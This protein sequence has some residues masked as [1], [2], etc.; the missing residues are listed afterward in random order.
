MKK[1]L[2]ILV[3]CYASLLAAQ[4]EAIPDSIRQNMYK[5]AGI[6]QGMAYNKAG[7]WCMLIHPDSSVLFSR[8]ALAIGL[9]YGNIEVQG[10]ALGIMAESYFYQS[11]FDSSVTCYWKA[12]TICEKT[13]NRKKLANYLNGVGTVFY[14]MG[15]FN[16]AAFYM[17]KAAKIKLEDG[18]MVAYGIILTNLAAVFQ[19]WEKYE[20]SIR[21][22][23]TA[24]KILTGTPYTGILAN[25]YNSMGSAFQLG[26]NNL[27]SAEFYYLKNVEMI[28]QPELET[29]RL[30]A[31]A[32]LGELYLQKN[33]LDQAEFYLQKAL[34]LSFTFQ[35]RAERASIYQRLG[36]LYEKKGVFEKA[37]AFQKKE[38]LLKDSIFTEDNQVVVQQLETQY[39][40][41]KKDAQIK[42]QQLAIQKRKNRENTLVFISILIVLLLATV[43]L[44]FILRTRAKTELEKTKSRIF[45]NIVH[46]IRTPLTLIHGPLQLLKK[47]YED[48][49]SKE[50]FRLIERN[51][52]RLM[53]LVDELLVAAKLEK[54][55]Y[56][57]HYQVGD[58][59]LFTR[60]LVHSFATQAEEKNIQLSFKANKEEALINFA[61][62]AFE[63]ILVNLVS[64]AIKYNPQGGR[65]EVEL[66][67]SGKNIQIRVS[68]TGIGMSRKDRERIFER[69]Y[70]V[71]HAM[72]QA[73]FGIGLS[74]VK[75]LVDLCKGHIA[76]ESSEGVGTTITVNVPYHPVAAELGPEHSA[77]TGRL[78]LL[79]EDDE[80]I[81]R[82]IKDILLKQA[83]HI[84]QAHDG[85]EG[86]RLALD[87]VP[88]MII[89]DIM[90]PVEDG[91]SM[92]GRLK[93]HE[94]TRQIPI[95]M[96]SSRQSIGSRLEGMGVGADAYLAKPFNPDE[97]VLQVKNILQT[98]QHNR[99]LYT[100]AIK[101]DARPYQQ[102]VAGNDAYLQKIVE[103]VDKHILETE[104]SVNE[105]ADSM[106]ISRSQLHRKI[107]SLTGLSTTH[108]IRIIRLE[109]AKDLLLANT[110]N[111][112]EVAY[113]SGFN[114]QSY[115]T[116]SFTEH[117]G[118]S[119][120]EFI[121]SK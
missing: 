11:A 1:I 16:K 57:L 25:L 111:I 21:A 99:S 2:I 42:V 38:V 22:L 78:V 50:N 51:S 114:S 104:F 20:E 80:E 13:G 66:D 87:M 5:S 65:V 101:E 58:M 92:T 12:I 46:E 3:I 94:L 70:R 98:L 109:K 36:E 115:F 31:F 100:E 34:I 43:A 27:D 15:D 6:E 33:N 112:T 32:N 9:Y 86:Y 41:E 19:R 69:F 71:N 116:K 102:R 81:C 8:H 74:I 118:M 61:A 88:D 110:G 90:M 52:N 85:A 62:S 48:E 89:T 77:D 121:K 105:L 106:S 35:R 96:L 75:E 60:N 39:Q 64:N 72:P 120:S 95:L 23:R 53:D 28:N 18:E 7:R 26:Y 97:L 91:V 79:V 30:S 37:Y 45:Q 103:V 117:F 29:F 84:Q 40:T 76:V 47:E 108:F 54:N 82:F 10:E 119:P 107:T 68:D 17:E 56:Q 59:V 73:G 113:E 44:Y 63:K 93:T 49:G 83:I 67:V 24:E 14:Q 55:E 4:N